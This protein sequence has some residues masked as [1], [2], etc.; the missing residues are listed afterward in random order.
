MPHLLGLAIRRSLCVKPSG[1]GDD[2]SATQLLVEA[3]DPAI[4]ADISTAILE[5]DVGLT[6]NN[7]GT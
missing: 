7:D 2:G 6:P 1:L 5:S 4:L 3:Y